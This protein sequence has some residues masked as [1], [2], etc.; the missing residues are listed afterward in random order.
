MTEDGREIGIQANPAVFSLVGTIQE[1]THHFAIEYHKKLREKT[2]RSELEAISGIGP[3]RR[4]AL[5]KT[6]KT[7]KA[8]GEAS[9]EQLMLVV[10]RP[11]AQAVYDHFHKE[12]TSCE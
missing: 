4:K 12:E 6:F 11:T 2:I 5:L 3:A 9:V 1:E 7:T 8:I 10:P